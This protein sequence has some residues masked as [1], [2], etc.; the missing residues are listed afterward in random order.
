VVT[1]EKKGSASERDSINV[2]TE[3]SEALESCTV[4]RIKFGVPIAYGGE[5]INRT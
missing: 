3:G 2:L 1:G 5:R 4:S